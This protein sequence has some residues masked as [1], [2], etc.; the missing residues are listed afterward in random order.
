MSCWCWHFH[1]FLESAARAECAA[2]ASITPTPTQASRSTARRSFRLCVT[3]DRLPALHNVPCRPAQCITALG[4]RH[5][6]S[7]P[8]LH[9]A[10][11]IG[12]LWEL[13][14]TY[15]S[16]KKK[17][18]F[19][20][21]WS[22]FTNWFEARARSCSPEIECD[23]LFSLLLF[24]WGREKSKLIIVGHLVGRCGASQQAHPHRQT[25]FS[26]KSSKLCVYFPSNPIQSIHLLELETKDERMRLSASAWC[27]DKA[28]M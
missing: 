17:T 18:A 15:L 25:C 21:A 28:T 24:W 11:G 12:V 5:L 6:Q 14:P 20:L 19:Q 13:R 4:T 7:A 3:W 27:V 26:M 9:S 23:S 2:P 10:T 1:V 8:R 22:S 16:E